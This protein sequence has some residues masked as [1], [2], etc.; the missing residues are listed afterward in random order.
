MQLLSPRIF[1]LVIFVLL[2]QTLAGC[3]SSSGSVGD[4][5]LG[6][7]G[8]VAIS[9]KVTFDLVG[10]SGS[11]A[12]D[13][14]GTVKTSSKGV[15]VEAVCNSVI[16]STTTGT[17]TAINDDG[18]FS[19]QIPAGTKKVFIRVK[20]E[21]KTT[22][23][24]AWDF[25]VVD[26][27]QSQ[28]LYAMDSAVFDVATTN[29]LNKDLH[30][31]SGWTGASYGNA[32]VAAPFAILDS[33]YQSFQ[34]VLNENTS[35]I[36][37][38]LKINWST[39]NVSFDG[40]INIGQIGTS[41]YSPSKT[42]IFLLGDAA[43]DTDEY[44]E[45]VIIHEWAHY[46]E[47]KFSRTDSLGGLHSRGD[48]LDMRVAFGEGF[49]NAFSAMVTD[50]PVYS[51]S[52]AAPNAA[53]QFNIENNSTCL[54]PG[55]FNECSIHAILYDLYDSSVGEA[56]DSVSLGFSPVYSVMTNEHKNTDALTSIFSFIFELKTNVTAMVNGTSINAAINTLLAGSFTNVVADEFGTGENKDAGMGVDVIPVYTDI[57]AGATVPSL[58]VINVFGE[59]IATGT[60]N[61]FFNGNRLSSYRFL[62]FIPPST[63]NYTITVTN[64]SGAGVDPDIALFQRGVK[65][66]SAIG[67]TTNT[68]SLTFGLTAGVTYI[69]QANDAGVT[70]STTPVSKTCFQV[71]LSN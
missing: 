66:A 61:E 23:I 27:T 56:V 12:L 41:F 8:N 7:G 21:M 35:T 57:T 65:I 20:A 36:F 44:D 52:Q 34:K 55:W 24:P 19:L 10:H 30:A 68:E 1:Y 15:T 31:A 54:N 39:K 60:G 22:G 48:R 62:K 71:T 40:N 28:G 37:P 63:K 46:F 5:T 64:F 11:G 49:G 58:C 42:E 67:T 45:H 33:V 70:F 2:L 26:N 47:D 4:C 38:A 43:S 25:T 6:T 69:I 3:S 53:L 18:K 9:G 50:N 13:Y 51:D 16:A 29:I 17:N 14:V 59:T 32:R